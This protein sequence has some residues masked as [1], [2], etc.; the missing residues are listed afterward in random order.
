MGW[1]R[2]EEVWGYSWGEEGRRKIGANWRRGREVRWGRE[3]VWER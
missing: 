1:G 2:R 3:G